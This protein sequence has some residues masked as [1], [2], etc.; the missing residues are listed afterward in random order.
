MFHVLERKRKNEMNVKDFLLGVALEERKLLD[1]IKS[2]FPCWQKDKEPKLKVDSIEKVIRVVKYFGIILAFYMITA[3]IG[4]LL[5]NAEYF[6]K[7]FIHHV[8]F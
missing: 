1:E 3:A 5:Q 4:V 2:S 6:Y 8:L 7:L